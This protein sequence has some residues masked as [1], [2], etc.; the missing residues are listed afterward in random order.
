MD[1]GTV[2]HTSPL[3]DFEDMIR[4]LSLNPTE[5]SETKISHQSSVMTE[6]PKINP[7]KPQKSTSPNHNES[8]G[9]MVV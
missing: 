5:Q 9:I 7:C 2:S 6:L 4:S 8:E 3:V 1:D